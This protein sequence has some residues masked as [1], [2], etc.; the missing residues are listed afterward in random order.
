MRI[1]IKPFLSIFGWLF[2]AYVLKKELIDIEHFYSTFIRPVLPYYVIILFMLI[3][4]PVWMIYNK[5]RFSGFKDK[6]AGS[7]HRVLGEQVRHD[8]NVSLEDYKTAIRCGVITVYFDEEANITAIRDMYPNSAL[9]AEIVFDDGAM[10]VYAADDFRAHRD[11]EDRDPE[12]LWPN[13]ECSVS[14]NK[15]NSEPESAPPTEKRGSD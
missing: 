8:M 6:R 1:I 10:G 5:R 7:A 14:D 12:D 3:V 4:V 13:S 11:P 15:T 2:T 9:M